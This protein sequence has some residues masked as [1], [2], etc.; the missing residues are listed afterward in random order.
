MKIQEFQHTEEN[1]QWKDEDI[2][3]PLIFT[4]NTADKFFKI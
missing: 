4:Q 3:R 2:K 1:L